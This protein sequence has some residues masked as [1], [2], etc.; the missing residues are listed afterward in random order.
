MPVARSAW[1]IRRLVRLSSRAR[2]GRR[3]GVAVEAALLMPVVL[4][5]LAGIADYGDAARARMALVSAVRSGLQYA[6]HHSADPSRVELAVRG[7]LTG[8]P[9]DITVA[10]AQTCECPDGGEVSCTGTCGVGERRRAFVSIAVEQLHATLMTWP[11]IDNPTI[12]KASAR[13]RIQ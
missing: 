1:W 2:L 10:V 9:D 7:A 4:F 13:V 12:L 3:G 11:G 6:T 5:M 8:A